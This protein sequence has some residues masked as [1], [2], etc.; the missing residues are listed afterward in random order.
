MYKKIFNLTGTEQQQ[1]IAA[2]AMD[3]IF[4]PWEK[5]T[6]RFTYFEIGWRD[7][8]NRTLEGE[9]LK[10]EGVH[11]ED[12]DK[13]EGM[14]NGKKYILGIF[15]PYSGH[16]YIDL[17][18][19]N[20]VATAETT[21]SAELAHLVDFFLPLSD[22]HKRELVKLMY[23][24]E[25]GHDP[26]AWWEK[27]DYS[28]EYYGLTGE[29]FMQAFTLAYSDMDFDASRF[30]HTITKEEAYRVR[31]ILRIERTDYLAPVIPTPP[32]VFKRF[33]NSQVYHDLD[34]YGN[35]P[36][37]HKI[38]DTTGLRPCKVCKPLKK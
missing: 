5:L 38:Y 17:A 27:Y 31:E 2:G 37:A 9:G 13:I 7:L 1:K 16:S 19:V 8:N 29:S 3:K 36:D 33:G 15:Y 32:P 34:H 20:Y 30:R 35:D 23:G 18:L 10:H 24:K 11:P 4:F 14:L 28:T 12:F 25:T 6:P 22:E 21:V 26:N